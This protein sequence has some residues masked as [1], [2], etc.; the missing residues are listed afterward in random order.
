MVWPVMLRARGEQRKAAIAAMSPGSCQRFRGTSRAIF[1]AVQSSKALP[2]RWLKVVP[3]FP[4]RPVEHRL[5]HTGIERVD[6]DAERCQVPRSALREVDESGLR[7]AV[8]RVR[9]RSDLAGHAAEEQQRAGLAF[10][11]AR[12]ERMG[13]MDR[14]HQVHPQHLVPVAGRQVPE[15]HAELSRADRG[16]VDDVVA[17]AEAFPHLDGRL[18]HGR[19]ID[20]IDH[21]PVRRA[22]AAR[23]RRGVRVAVEENDIAAFLDTLDGYRLADTAPPPTTTTTSP[24]S[25]RSILAT[26]QR[27]GHLRAQ[28]TPSRDCS[29]L[30]DPLQSGA[31]VGKK[32]G[33]TIKR[34][35]A[36]DSPFLCSGPTNACR[37]ARFFR[38]RVSS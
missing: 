37:R 2:G 25:M 31:A 19:D 16:R 29:R 22:Q 21:D 5:D 38:G 17:V 24:A 4:D 26:P 34:L 27:S 11:H 36:R 1:S 8:G 10:R 7:G 23:Q 3:A 12:R 18:T 28:P 9:R 32:A 30:P 15:R 13:H 20:H 33:T 6:P 35:A 14:A